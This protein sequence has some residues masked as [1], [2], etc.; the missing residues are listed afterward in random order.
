MSEGAEKTGVSYASATRGLWHVV[1][2]SAYQV[3]G[4]LWSVRHADGLVKS[5]IEVRK[6]DDALAERVL[7]RPIEG[8]DLL[9]IGTGTLASQAL[10]FACRGNRVTSIDLE[11]QTA[12]WDVRQYVDLWRHNGPRRALKTLARNVIGLDRA[13]PRALV[14]QMGLSARPPLT[15]LRMNAQQLAFPDAS[16][17]VV[18]SYDVLEHVEDLGAVLREV[19]RVLR[20]GGLAY[21]V[22]MPYTCENG[23]HDYRQISGGRRDLPLWAHLR[24][25]HA[26]SVQPGAYVNKLG[27]EDVRRLAAEHLPGAEIGAPRA[28]D[29]TLPDKL[30]VLRAEGEL[31]GYTDEELLAVRMQIFWRKPAGK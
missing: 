8:L 1:R 3:K 10:Y 2:E 25:A 29:P 17:D 9:D 14:R 30:R 24:P 4:H 21:L 12:G 26:A 16:F 15:L 18:H 7:G 19:A 13:Y 31:A 5:L 22:V 20:P 11:Q 28:A 6:A 27:L 23:A